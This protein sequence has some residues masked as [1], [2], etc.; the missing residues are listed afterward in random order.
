M[1][2]QDGKNIVSRG[3]EGTG[4]AVIYQDRF[5]P[6][7]GFMEYAQTQRLNKA[8]QGIAQLAKQKEINKQLA[9]LDFTAADDAD[10]IELTEL[11][12]GLMES[13][14]GISMQP[15]ADIMD[16]TS[17]AGKMY[18]DAQKALDGGSTMS[19]DTAKT[20]RAMTD[21]YQ[22]DPSAF[23]GEAYVKGLE[24]YKNLPT[25]K[26]RNEFLR[27][28]HPSGFG[29]GFMVPEVGLLSPVDELSAAEYESV[30]EVGD[31]TTTTGGASTSKTKELVM[32]RLL[33]PGNDQW[34]QRYVGKGKK[35]A[36]VEEG[37][38]FLAK[39]LTNQVKTTAKTQL[40]EK[41]SPWSFDFSSGSGLEQNGDFVFGYGFEKLDG[42]L[43]GGATTMTPNSEKQNPVVNI[44]YKDGKPKTF[45]YTSKNKEGKQEQINVQPTGLV[46]RDG[47]WY[48]RGT[49]SQ[50]VPES[51]NMNQIVVIGGGSAERGQ[52]VEF[53]LDKYDNQNRFETQFQTSME[54][55]NANM[56]QVIG[57]TDKAV[58]KEVEKAVDTGVDDAFKAVKPYGN[59]T[60][61]DAETLANYVT[62][63]KG[64]K[65]VANGTTINVT[66]GSNAGNYDMT[67]PAMKLLFELRFGKK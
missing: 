66:G 59:V 65:A 17:E 57:E 1:A 67:D 39:D 2:Q 13:V 45:D 38:D 26:A 5:D 11:K 30:L 20:F 54:R 36:T 50:D 47:Q 18:F 61:N 58:T 3:V 51:I 62:T 49:L 48:G 23:D 37:V 43:W 52:M 46:K 53:P 24:E 7:A 35:F 63:E 10:R 32:N 15:G 28:E 33:D 41:S 29:V 25:M 9:E 27:R 60:A 19:A 12:D 4:R 22:K 8:N 31:V 40:D 14:V 56:N 16:P 34:I 64:A 21:A 44:S 6:A 55:I 42:A